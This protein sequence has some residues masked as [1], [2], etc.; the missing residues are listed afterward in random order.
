MSRKSKESSDIIGETQRALIIRENYE[1][2][3]KDAVNWKEV[4]QKSAY[5]K[6][7]YL[8]TASFRVAEKL[9]IA[10]SYTQDSTRN[11]LSFAPPAAAADWWTLAIDSLLRTN[12]PKDTVLYRA[13]HD[14]RN[15]QWIKLELYFFE[16]K[17]QSIAHN[18]LYVINQSCI[19]KWTNQINQTI[20]RSST[21]LSN[22]SINHSFTHSI[23]QSWFNK[24]S[25]NWP[26]KYWINKWTIN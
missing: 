19:N 20:K 12:K 2:Q 18:L 6:R 24:L 5:K 11:R 13:V 25:I 9:E 17:E 21:R 1:S 10:Q 7:S 22:Q 23:N 15:G 14:V 8:R 3:K 26:K 4:G 16:R